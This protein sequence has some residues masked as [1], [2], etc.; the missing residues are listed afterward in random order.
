MGKPTICIGKNKGADTAKLIS[1]FV[2]VYSP[3]C[4]GPVLNPNC[5]FFSCTGSNILAGASQILLLVHTVIFSIQLC[6][7]PDY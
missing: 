2:F 7:Y 4:V 1:A 6:P 5:W 3:V